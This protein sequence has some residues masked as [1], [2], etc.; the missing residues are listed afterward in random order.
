MNISVSI[1]ASVTVHA[2]GQPSRCW[3]RCSCSTASDWSHFLT[4]RDS[5]RKTLPSSG[6]HR[7]RTYCHPLMWAYISYL[8][9]FIKDVRSK[10]TFSTTLRPLSNFVRFE[11]THPPPS[12]TSTDVRM[13]SCINNKQ[14]VLDVLFIYIRP[15]LPPRLRFSTLVHTHPPHPAPFDRTSVMNGP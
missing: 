7:C 10:L 2:T 14:S 1:G 8:W 4:I 11:Y 12:P 5:S 9:S 15:P 13:V 3:D 6:S